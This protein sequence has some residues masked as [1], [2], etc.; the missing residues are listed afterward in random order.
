MY[1]CRA[2]VTACAVIILFIVD[3]VKNWIMTLELA[4]HSGCYL[5]Y[6]YQY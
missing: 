2:T 3:L 6:L 1:V 5:L 4:S